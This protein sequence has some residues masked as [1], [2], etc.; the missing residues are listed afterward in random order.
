MS[1]RVTQ[2]WTAIYIYIWFISYIKIIHSKLWSI[3]TV[4]I[5]TISLWPFNFYRFIKF[6]NQTKNKCIWISFPTTSMIPCWFRA[7]MFFTHMLKLIQAL[8]NMIS[9]KMVHC[10]RTLNMTYKSK[11]NETNRI[12]SIEPNPIFFNILIFFRV[13]FDR[14]QHRNS[15]KVRN[16]CYVDSVQK[17]S[18]ILKFHW[19]PLY[20]YT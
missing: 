9:N 16:S 10:S 11:R 7:L 15:E 17:A 2:I 8:L 20:W 13:Q 3:I 4:T 14:T 1:I 18:K 19:S 5:N 6:I 12:S